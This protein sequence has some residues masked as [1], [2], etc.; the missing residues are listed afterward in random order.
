MAAQEEKEPGKLKQMWRVLQMTR[1]G[2]KWIVPMLI[3]SFLGPLALGIVL[4]FTVLPGGIFT[5]ILWITTGVLA[6]LLLALVILGNRAET[7]AYRQIAGQPGAVGAILQGSLRR[8][9]QTSEFPVQVN[10]RT[11]DAIYRAVGKC[12]VVL[13]AEGPK[14]RVKKILDDEKKM[15]ARAVPQVPIHIVH[16]GPDDDSTALPKLRKTLYRFK[17]E[18]NK[19]EVLAVSHRLSS[20]KKPGTIPMPKGIDPFKMRAPKPR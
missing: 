6:G 12:G 2:D 8:A 1:R 10:P 16:V 7:V 15:V 18:L 14:T 11:Q 17:K 4:P 9:W 19:A 5:K 20:L 13:I 3:V